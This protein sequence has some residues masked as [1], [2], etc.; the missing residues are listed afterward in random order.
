MTT[1]FLQLYKALLHDINKILERKLSEKEAAELCFR[2]SIAHWNAL[3]DRVKKEGF[4]SDAEEIH[5]FKNTKPFFTGQIEYFIQRYHALQFLP[6]GAEARREFWKGEMARLNHFF[7][8]YQDF[9]TYYHSRQTDLDQRYFL[10]RH[11]DGSNLAHA[12]VYD[13]DQETAT[14]HDWLLTNMVAY[15]KYKKYVEEELGKD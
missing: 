13:L 5:F 3:K 7:D 4:G 10:V 6:S 11:S 15:E 1:D 14:S 2:C 12:A 8:S 9:F